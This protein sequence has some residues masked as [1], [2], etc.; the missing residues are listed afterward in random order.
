VIQVIQQIV[1]AMRDRAGRTLYPASIGGILVGGVAL[2]L[3]GLLVA[4]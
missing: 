3:T 2:Y 4:T 1:P